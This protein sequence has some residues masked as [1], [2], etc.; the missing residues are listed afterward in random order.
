MKFSYFSASTCFDCMENCK[1]Y[2]SLRLPHEC[3]AFGNRICSSEPVQTH[4]NMRI[5]DNNHEEWKKAVNLQGIIWSQFISQGSNTGAIN[6]WLLPI[7]IWNVCKLTV[8]WAELST[9]PSHINFAFPNRR[10]FPL[11][12]MTSFALLIL[13]VF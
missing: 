9:I 10:C 7:L 2:I 1:V 3:L 11:G 12:T 13:F 5:S 4:K 8:Q 6:S